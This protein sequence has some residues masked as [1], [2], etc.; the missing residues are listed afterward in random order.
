MTSPTIVITEVTDPIEIA[1]AREQREKFE[2]NLA[3]LEANATEVYS[4]R[5][6]YI[7]IAGQE[8]FVGDSVQE[9]IKEAKT[10][11]PDDNGLFTRI[12]PKERGEP[13][14]NRMPSV[15]VKRPR[16]KDETRGERHE[17]KMPTYVMSELNDPVEAVLA[18]EHAEKFKQNCDWL[19]A[20][21]KKFIATE[22]NISALPDSSYSL[23]KM[24][25]KWSR[26]HVP[27]IPMMML[28]L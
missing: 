10:K 11:H 22:E 6:K 8:I 26:G 17:T 27:F 13:I 7:C 3:W 25:K 16:E 19:T 23:G 9:I 1:K 24:S 21:A 18:S 2:R 20:N 14:G 5:G 28:L 12:V 15:W 4:H